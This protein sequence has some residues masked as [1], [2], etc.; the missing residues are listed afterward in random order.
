MLSQEEPVKLERFDPA[1]KANV[2]VPID[3]SAA[4][5]EDSAFVQVRVFFQND[6]ESPQQFPLQPDPLKV[7]FWGIGPPALQ[8]KKKPGDIP[9]V[10]F[11]PPVP[12][13]YTV[14]VIAITFVGGASVLSAW[15]SRPITV[16]A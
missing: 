15:K 16:Q 12:G 2:I 11:T 10:G 4:F 9:T 7:G 6:P 14:M 3:L 8:L 1:Y 13:Y 5:L